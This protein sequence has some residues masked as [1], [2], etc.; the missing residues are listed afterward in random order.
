MKLTEADYAQ[1]FGFDI[2]GTGNYYWFDGVMHSTRDRGEWER[3]N[4]IVDG[5]VVPL[6]G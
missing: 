1:F 3:A 6:Y 5:V 2:Y 4:G